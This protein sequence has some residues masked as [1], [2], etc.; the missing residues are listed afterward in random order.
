LA[1]RESSHNS[2]E[3][4]G[5]TLES[6]GEAASWFLYCSINRQALSPTELRLELTD[7]KKGALCR[8][9][10]R[11]LTQGRRFSTLQRADVYRCTGKGVLRVA[12]P[13]SG[14]R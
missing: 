11:Q 6:D 8:G 14:R 9:A 10:F 2:Q 12:T 3:E 7:L 5:S 4:R 13:I 1:Q